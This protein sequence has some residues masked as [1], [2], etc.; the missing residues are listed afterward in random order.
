[1]ITESIRD[2]LD[3]VERH[4]P[5]KPVVEKPMFGTVAIMLDGEM[6]VAAHR[7]GSLLVRVSRDAD[8]ELMRR[9]EASRLVMGSKQ[10]GAGWIR[11]DESA[12]ADDEQLGFWIDRALER[13]G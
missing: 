4:L 6:V 13:R 7:D 3:R 8:A 11:V 10:M 12:V 1:M 5:D 9:P 2:L